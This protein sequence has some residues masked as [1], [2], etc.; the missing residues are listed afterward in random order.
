MR[1][2]LIKH[3]HLTFAG[4][5]GERLTELG[6]DLD[7]RLVVSAEDHHAPGVQFDFPDPLDYGLIV[8]MGSPWSVNDPGVASWVTPELAMLGK[9]HAAGVP[10][11]GVCFGGQALAAALGGAVERAPRPELGWVD[12]ETDDPSLVA[13]G[14]WFQ[15]HYDRWRLPPGAVE[16]ARTAVG[17]QAFVIG[18]SMGLQFHPEITPFELE[19]WLGHGGDAHMRAAGVD[20]DAVLEEVRRTE[21]DS[22]R[23]TRALVDAF[24]TRVAAGDR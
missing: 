10:V 17:S 3:D 11:L 7:E 12:V 23:R 13:P 9:A 15:F 16:I 22:A 5:V 8:P 14:P 2:L 21:A 20:P 18:R 4:P 6:W 24:L 1:A 19:C